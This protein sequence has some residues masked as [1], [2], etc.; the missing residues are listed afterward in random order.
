MILYRPV[1]LTELRLIYDTGLSAFP[2]RL[3]EQP[4][5]YP[6]LNQEYAAQIASDW[7]AK[8][9]EAAGYVTRFE[10]DRKFV[11]RYE[12]RQVGARQHQELWVPADD[13]ADFNRH[14]SPPI[15]V[16]DA[17]FGAG[18]KGLVPTNLMLAGKN[19]VEQLL[20]LDQILEN[21]SFDF[22]CEIGA[23]HVAIFL[24]YPFWASR[25][26]AADG[27][28][29]D[30]RDRILAGIAARWTLGFADRP[31]PELRAHAA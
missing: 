8:S 27:V 14:I 18:F 22:F 20:A 4:I 3:P 1:G 5:F 15:A 16:S 19:A 25:D 10:V 21:S 30:R 13:L 6:V 28:P 29:V 24:H 9:E 7:N 31:L 2:R 17:Y 26:F 23:N 11:E 12:I